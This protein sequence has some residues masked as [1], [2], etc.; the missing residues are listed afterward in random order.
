MKKTLIAFSVTIMLSIALLLGVGLSACDWFNTSVL[1]KPSQEEIAKKAE[2]Q[3]RTESRRD[4]MRLAEIANRNALQSNEEQQA[5]LDFSSKPFH[6]IVG[7][8]EEQSNVDGM[9][10]TLKAKGFQ[11]NTFKLGGLTCVS[12]I[13]YKT[14]LEAETEL[15]KL[16]D[17]DFCPDDAWVYRKD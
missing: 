17:N 15:D 2:L 8:Y 1:G 3:L 12:A 10:A 6:L 9:L 7:C 4:S 13:S 14:L 16:M 11:A 5:N